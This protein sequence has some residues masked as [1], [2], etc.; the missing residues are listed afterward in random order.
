MKDKERVRT[1][2]APLRP[3]PCVEGAK[4]ALRL[5]EIDW[6][7]ALEEALECIIKRGDNFPGLMG[8]F[9]RRLL[10]LDGSLGSMKNRLDDF[11]VEEPKWIGN[12]PNTVEK[13]RQLLIVTLANKVR[14]AQNYPCTTGDGRAQ[15]LADILINW[16][17]SQE[18]LRWYMREQSDLSLKL[19]DMIHEYL[20]ALCWA[21]GITDLPDSDVGRVEALLLQARPVYEAVRTAEMHKG[22]DGQ[23]LL[24]WRLVHRAIVPTETPEGLFPGQFEP[25]EVTS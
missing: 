11:L 22:E 14:G 16:T 12:A 1:Y 6:P 3:L 5:E 2:G 25:I 17:E 21:W 24:E 18:I 13:Q 10:A 19:S 20:E 23:Q 9:L 8:K 4:A 7:L 15:D